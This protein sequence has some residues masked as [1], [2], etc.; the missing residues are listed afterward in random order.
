MKAQS[1]LREGTRV[2]NC[3]V[4]SS[5]YG[6]HGVIRNSLFKSHTKGWTRIFAWVL[7]DDGT[8]DSEMKKYLIREDEVT[9]LVCPCCKHETGWKRGMGYEGSTL[10][11]EFKCS[12][13]GYT[14]WIPEYLLK[15]ME[16][17]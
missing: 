15:K 4:L 14:W 6:K 3:F 9:R 13:C 17:S 11:Y 16:I 2:I 1:V 5:E 10:E 12:D 8:E 7:Y